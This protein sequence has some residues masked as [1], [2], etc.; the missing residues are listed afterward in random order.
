[1]DKFMECT[2]CKIDKPRKDFYKNKAAVDGTGL[3][4]QCKDCHKISRKKS[5]KKNKTQIYA[6]IK[7]REIAKREYIDKKYKS[8][9]CVDCKN[10]F[11]PICMDFDHL[12]ASLKIDGV[13]QLIHR[14]AS[15]KKIE[16]EIKKCE[17]VCSNCHRLRTL[18]RK[19]ARDI[20]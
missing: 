20:N 9:P 11:H 12:D 4:N 15:L 6:Q 10:P 13:S 8:D 14:G 17:V 2:K 19:L 1:M 5:F 16:A 3:H 18:A 7:Q